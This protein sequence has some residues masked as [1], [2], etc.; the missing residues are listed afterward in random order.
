MSFRCLSVIF[1]LCIS[2]KAGEGRVLRVCADPNNLPFSNQAGDGLE[3]HL[4][5]LIAKDL[6][7]EVSYTWWTETKSFVKN[8]L[9]ENQCDVIMGV[10]STLD[11]V[12]PTRPYYR[13]TYVFVTRR[14]RALNIASLTDPRLEKLR[15]GI[16]VVGDDY[17]PPAHLLA[18]LGLG[19]QIVGYSLFGPYGESNP[20]SQVIDAVTNGDV[21]IAVVWGPF[22]GFFAKQQRAPLT[23]TPVS[24]QMFLAI[25]FTYSISAAVRKGD[26][27]LR[28]EI[29]NA[30]DRECTS[31]NA[32]L[33]EYG[34][35]Q[36]REDKPRCDSSQP[37]AASLR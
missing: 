1:F 34:F 29:Q 5:N 33:I 18:R 22:A 10:P 37:A 7:A 15:I 2:L 6:N 16:H 20:A 31:I 14:D 35:P 17:A 24:P 8:S 28:A 12:S 13:S 26:D 21:D 30:L 11:S 36:V 27:G 3:N 4:A 9:G 19:K 25:P 32:L 23:I